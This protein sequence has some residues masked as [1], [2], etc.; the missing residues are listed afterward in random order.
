MLRILFLG[1]FLEEFKLKSCVFCEAK[2]TIF[3]VVMFIDLGYER[4]VNLFIHGFDTEN[5]CYVLQL[6]NSIR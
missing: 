2:F 4:F 1:L 3:L 6:C 5:T